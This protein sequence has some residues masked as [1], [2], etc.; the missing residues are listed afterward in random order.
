MA[1][2]YNHTHHHD[3]QTD[4][5]LFGGSIDYRGTVTEIGPAGAGSMTPQEYYAAAGVTAY[6]TNDQSSVI[7]NLPTESK[8]THLPIRAN[9]PDEKV[10]QG[11][12]YVNSLDAPMSLVE[13]EAMEQPVPATSPISPRGEPVLEKEGSTVTDQQIEDEEKYVAAEIVMMKEKLLSYAKS[14]LYQ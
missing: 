11:T 7:R 3:M 1:G 12:A 13:A 9:E 8:T 14:H 10:A 2:E 5:G 6:A 4:I